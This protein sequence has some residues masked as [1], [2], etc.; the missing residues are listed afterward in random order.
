MD[1]HGMW[2]APLG[3]LVP[4]WPVE[5][6]CYY[7]DRGRQ[8]RVGIERLVWAILTLRWSSWDV[9]TVKHWVDGFDERSGLDKHL[10]VFGIFVVFKGRKGHEGKIVK[11]M[12]TDR[13]ENWGLNLSAFQV[14]RGG[15]P[16]ADEEIKAWG[17]EQSASLWVA[18]MGIHGRVWIWRLCY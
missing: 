1:G 17:L 18:K 15:K 8:V 13:K 14:A 3:N 5:W 6:S 16:T 4:K 11:E 2:K 7:Q 10:R 12:S 9:C